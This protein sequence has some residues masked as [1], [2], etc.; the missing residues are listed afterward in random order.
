MSYCSEN[1]LPLSTSINRLFEVI[2]LLGFQKVRNSLKIDNQIGSYVWIGRG[3]CI[4]FVALEL[5]VYRNS[6]C[7]SV[8]TRTRSG[9]SY[10]DLSW[11]NKTI[12]LLKGL[13]VGSFITDEGTNRYMKLDGIE[14]SKVACSLFVDRWRFNNAMIK[15]KIYLQSRKM[16]GDIASEKYSGFPWLDDINPRILSDNMIVPYLI[17]SWES[18]FRN[19]YISIL[20]YSNRIPEKALKNCRISSTDYLMVIRQEACLE[21]LLA[22][23]LSFQRPNVIAEN[24]RLL[25]SDIDINAWLRKPYNKRK[26][27]LFDS[28][29][30]IVEIRDEIVHT[31]NM[32]LSILDDQIHKIIKDLTIA[33]E[34]S[35]QGF[36]QVFGFKPDYDF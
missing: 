25:N 5:Y 21:R 29:I 24:F 4:S 30:E 14:P 33:V 16:T 3:D 36:G 1:K 32:N 9:R 19:S 35:Y 7:I 11:Q 31:G 27:T 12:S 15:P 22:D 23:S 13:F 28:I 20:K 8:Q 18:Y 2:E 34:R 10:W 17:G 6:D 26:K